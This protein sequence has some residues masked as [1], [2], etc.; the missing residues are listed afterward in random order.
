MEEN[1]IRKIVQ[2]EFEKLK[3]KFFE[4]ERVKEKF[5]GHI[6]FGGCGKCILAAPF[7]SLLMD[8]FRKSICHQYYIQNFEFFIWSKLPRIFIQI[9]EKMHF[10]SWNF[11]RLFCYDHNEYR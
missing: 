6:D 3:L 5:S 7:F 11:D 9:N 8:I 2:D 4:L 10:K 1:T